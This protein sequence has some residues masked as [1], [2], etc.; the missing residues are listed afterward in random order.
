MRVHAFLEHWG[1]INFNV[2]P[3]N[4]PTNPLL[5]KSFNFKSPVYVDASSFLVKDAIPNFGNKIGDNAVIL[6]NKQNEEFR[7][8]YPINTTPESLFRTIF[9]KNSVNV[10]NQINFLSKNYRPKCDMCSK[11]C[12]IEWYMQSDPNNAIEKLNK[13]EAEENFNHVKESLLICENCYDKGN[14]PKG[15]S[16]EDFELANFFNIVNPSESNILYFILRIP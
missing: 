10:I 7:T 14:L 16:K 12:N 5:P 13:S 9:N 3:N 15:L 6:T 2:D 11:L 4:K 1:I 8:L